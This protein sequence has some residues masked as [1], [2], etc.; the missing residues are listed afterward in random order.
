MNQ[1]TE[2][3]LAEHRD[4]LPRGDRSD[5]ED[6]H[7]TLVIREGD[8]FLLTDRTGNVPPGNERGLGLYR[9]D[10]RHLSGF[11]FYFHTCEPVVLLSTAELGFGSEH[12]LT[13]P[14]L[15]VGEDSFVPAG[16]IEIRRQRVLNGSLQETLHIT[17]YHDRAVPLQL[18][19]DLEADFA[20]IFKVRGFPQ[21]R[22]GE[23]L[24]TVVGQ[25]KIVFK[26]RGADGRTRT[27][28][29]S[30][31]SKPHLL[32]ASGAAFKLELRPRETWTV[33]IL[34]ATRE[35]QAQPQRRGDGRDSFQEAEAAYQMWSAGCTQVFTDNELFN[36]ALDRSLRDLRML[37]QETDEGLRFPV[38]G[39]PWFDALFG[40]DAIIVSLQTLAFRP[41]IARETLRTLASTSGRTVDHSREEQPGKIL[42]EMRQ[43]EMAL[44]GDVPYGRYYG[45]I[46]STPLFLLLA[47]EYYSWT[48]DLEF[49]NELRPHLLA[50]IEWLDNYG[51]SNGDGFVDYAG[52]SEAGLVNQGW[53]DSP[54]AIMH[55]DGSLAPGPIALVEVQ[56]YVYAA[57][58]RLAPVLEALGL[59]DLAKRLSREADD[60]QQRFEEAFWLPHEGLYALAIDGDG[61]ACAS[62]A[63]NASHAL[64]SGIA[65]P[66]HAASVVERMLS[67]DLFSGW[68]V[69]TL[70]RSNARFNPLGYHVGTVWPHDNAIAA[71]GFKMY[72]FED[73]ANEIATGLFDAAATF[74]YFRLP[75]LFGGES[76]T[77]YHAPVPYPVAC[78][79]QGW[80]AGAF[81]MLLHAMLGLK[82]ALNERTLFTIRPR[83]PYWLESVEIRNLQIGRG[84]IDLSLNRSGAQT[85]VK[86]QENSA[87]IQ[88]VPLDRW[89]A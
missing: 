19:L 5:V 4:T 36:K 25:D 76:R 41:Q 26:Y 10:T 71:F 35:E 44:T 13:N 7:D 32:S 54:E 75:E 31:S 2:H 9:Q 23:T 65:S 52:D 46:D 51:D 6:I 72:G 80:A 56:G 48:G 11:N 38:A 53:K 64:W 8:S 74:P 88:V 34:V 89:P 60:L 24:P 73:E 28:I 62:V 21:Q 15:E 27:T 17:N 83:L 84:S 20:D 50:A 82:P 42:H 70:A 22:P 49:L 59:V 63:S 79:P 43:G 55:A 69:R 67:N 29:V 12:V 47:A 18:H 1:N 86:V 40:R 77:P 61:R 14:P 81:P 68:G 78:R 45:S 3:H 85:L 66:E 30:F 37:W 58:R 87:G 57:K 33:Q 16:T 39:T